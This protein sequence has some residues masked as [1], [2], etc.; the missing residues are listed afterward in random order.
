MQANSLHSRL[1][2]ELWAFVSSA[3]LACAFA[4]ACEH[5]Q[6]QDHLPVPVR[7]ASAEPLEED[8]GLKYS[9]NIDAQTQ[10]TLA[11]KSGGYVERI[12]ERKGADA[13][14]RVLQVGD[15]VRQGEVLAKVRESEY[16]DRVNAANAALDQAQTG[17]EKAKLDFERANNLFKSD[18]LTK[19]QYDAAKA[20]LDQGAASVENARANLQQAKTSLSDCT[21]ISPLTGWVLARNIEVGSLVGTGSSAFVLADTHLVKASFGLPD[22]RVSYAQLGAPQTITT[23]S[24]P[25]EFHGRITAVSPSADPKSRVF[26][27]EVTIPNPEDKLKPGMI[28]TLSLGGGKVQR[29]PTTAVP[30]SA[31]VRSSQRPDAFAVFVVTDKGGRSVAQERSVEIGETVGN[32]ISI[33]KGL[34]VGERIVVTGS[35]LIRDGEE[36]KVIP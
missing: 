15:S 34:N 8:G 18:S 21:I 4:A 19:A 31:V 10:V 29:Q 26:L 25:G 11:F 13:R 24:L 33:A 27:V 5:G 9:A 17:Y 6:K 20:S 7:V 23:D 16:A 35:T 22:T 32:M 3:L 30:L 14:M 2:L 1:R 36:I 12:V 28:A